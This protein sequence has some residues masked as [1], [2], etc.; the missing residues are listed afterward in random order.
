MIMTRNGNLIPSVF[1]GS[2]GHAAKVVLTFVPIISKTLDWMSGSVSRLMCPFRTFLSQICKGLLPIEY[3]I[4]KK[5]DWKVFLNIAA[6]QG[7][8][9]LGG[10]GSAS[11][12]PRR[13]R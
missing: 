7:G 6:S 13:P 12:V 2:A 11:R 8:R 10:L 3:R 1:E 9:G 5:P 4:D